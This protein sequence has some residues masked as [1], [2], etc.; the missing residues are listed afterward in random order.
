MPTL[1]VRLRRGN[2]E[3]GKTVLGPGAGVQ[4]TFQGERKEKRRE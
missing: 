2:K 1:F 4:A 3:Q